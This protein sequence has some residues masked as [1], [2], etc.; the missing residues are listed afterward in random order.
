MKLADTCVW[1]EAFK[2]SATGKTYKAM[3]ARPGDILVPAVVQFELRRWALRE[4]G[5]VEADRIVVALQSA[6]VVP[7]D[8]SIALHAAD[9]AEA[10]KLHALDAMIYATAL[11]HA[12]E[13]VTCDAHFK[14]L[15]HVLYERKKA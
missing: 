1:I 13:L 6:R 9:L 12:A 10:H 4:L 3:L 5:E 11:A 15:P 2:D 14:G 7:I 8:E